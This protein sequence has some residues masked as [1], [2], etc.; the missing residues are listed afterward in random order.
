MFTVPSQL[1][2]RSN[3]LE[4]A[5]FLE[6]QVVSGTLRPNDRLPNTPEL[7]E[8]FGVSRDT[9]QRA[10]GRLVRRGLIKRM[11]RRGTFVTAGVASSTVGVVFGK[12]PFTS[13]SG[14]YRE[15]L[16]CFFR[17][18]RHLNMD[19]KA[20]LFLEESTFLS[21][22][23]ELE[24]DIR[25]GQLR[26]LVSIYLSGLLGHWMEDQTDLPILLP[27]ENDTEARVRMGLEHL[28]KRGR[29]RPLLLSLVSPD[30]TPTHLAETVLAEE[31]SGAAAAWRQAGMEGPP[32]EP[33]M[34]MDTDQAAYDYI[35]QRFQEAGPLPDAILV[36][37]DLN[38]KGVLFALAE[39]G[40]RMP[41]Q[42]ALVTHENRGCE[43]FF[44]KAL[45]RLVCDPRDNVVA[46]YTFLRQSGLP[47]PPGQHAVPGKIAPIL[48]EGASS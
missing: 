28:L 2:E 15:T 6:S 42:V 29:R 40:L 45:T 35:R 16:A 9:L 39:L 36:N 12:D 25:D 8:M 20:Y 27:P 43:H 34:L 22:V 10:L 31:R 17:E 7:L 26:C 21:S 37:H 3:Y 38:T 44:P 18:G 5:D 14:F 41:E 33:V 46:T 24:Q 19:V 48:I 1:R 47:L 11:P 32:P 4:I 13:S 30:N 23:R